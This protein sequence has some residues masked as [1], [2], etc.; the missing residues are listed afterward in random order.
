MAADA[1]GERDQE[2]PGIL[3]AGNAVEDGRHYGMKLRSVEV[4]YGEHDCTDRSCQVGE[5]L[6]RDTDPLRGCQ[7]L[8]LFL[9]YLAR[10]S[11]HGV[12]MWLFQFS[13]LYCGG[14]S[15]SISVS[16]WSRISMMSSTMS[17][18]MV[19]GG[20]RVMLSPTRIARPLSRTMSVNRLENAPSEPPG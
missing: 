18:V 11:C 6:L 9:C 10:L 2:T 20:D 12:L 5:L 13:T 8:H 7:S 15:L 1:I 16:D 14:N 19:M 4:V 3:L 17:F